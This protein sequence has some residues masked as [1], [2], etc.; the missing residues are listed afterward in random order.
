VRVRRQPVALAAGRER[1]DDLMEAQITQERGS[2]P[3]ASSGALLKR[4]LT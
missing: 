2:S 1:G 3:S 4:M